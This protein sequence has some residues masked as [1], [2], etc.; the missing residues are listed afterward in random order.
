MLRLKKKKL[1]GLDK[2]ADWTDEED[3]ELSK[4]QTF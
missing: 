4:P 2:A 3:L 1:L